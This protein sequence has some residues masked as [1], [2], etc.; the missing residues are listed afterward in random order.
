MGKGFRD[1]VGVDRVI[2]GADRANI[3][4]KFVEASVFNL[5]FLDS[6]FDSVCMFDVIE[7]LPRHSERAALAEV[8]RILQFGGKLYFSTP[9]ASPF[10]TP[11]DPVWWFGHRHYR[12]ATLRRL[13]MSEG[14]AIERVF[15]A[16]GALEGLEHIR[17]LVYKH[18]LHRPQPPIA[19]I[20]R[21]VER[22]HG[23]DHRFGMT[24]F[25]VAARRSI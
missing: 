12:R 4:T 15:V 18:A 20:D 14:F 24:L 7:H 13:L 17:H 19:F 5:P 6:A 23:A 9:H 3:G 10:H 1:Y 8:R 16:G 2:V 11:L 22:A 21:L 25:V